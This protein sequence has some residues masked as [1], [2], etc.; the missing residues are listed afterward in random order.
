MKYFPSFLDLKNKPV[1]IVGSGPETEIK[2]DQ[3]HESG[4]K[5]K[6]ISETI[7]SSLLQNLTSHNIDF[8][9]RE[10]QKSDLEGKWLVISTSEN[11]SINKKVFE[12]TSAKNIFSNVVDVTDMCSFIFPA[13]IHEKDVSIAISTSGNSPA[14][15]QRIKKEISGVI[16]P[17]YGNL[18]DLMGKIRP[19]I[20]KRINDKKKRTS[21]F[22]RMV[23]SDLLNLL[24][25]NKYEEAE[26]EAYKMIF[27]EIRTS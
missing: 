14:L 10:F 20:L 26:I 17:E 3:M 8:E 18:A 13:I 7:S 24:K 5:I 4:A 12:E 15:A 11:E 19:L 22:Q 9:I 27:E 25:S 1:L 6:Y 16:G 23:N 21:L 2:I